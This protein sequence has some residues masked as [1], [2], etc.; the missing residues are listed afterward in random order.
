MRGCNILISFRLSKFPVKEISMV[1]R[2]LITPTVNI[3][4]HL[5]SSGIKYTQNTTSCIL[6]VVNGNIE[7]DYRL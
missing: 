5:Y 2:I 1:R 7:I 6:V 3:Y 4:R